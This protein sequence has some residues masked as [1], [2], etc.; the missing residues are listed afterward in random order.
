MTHRSAGAAKFVASFRNC[1]YSYTLILLGRLF[2]CAE[3]VGF[4]E[5]FSQAVRTFWVAYAYFICWMIGLYVV[6]TSFFEPLFEKSI[7]S[8]A[9]VY[10]RSRN[11]ATHVS[12]SLLWSMRYDC[13]RFSKWVAKG[14]GEG[15]GHVQL[16]TFLWNFNA[17]LCLN[18]C[19]HWNCMQMCVVSSTVSCCFREIFSRELQI[20]RSFWEKPRKWKF[21]R[22]LKIREFNIQVFIVFIGSRPFL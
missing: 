17:T 18:Y 22:C 10:R 15:W 12:L 11:E 4:D 16:W 2:S 19:C 1:F 8:F 7:F 6:K 9:T 21:R 3:N 14:V 20:R 13:Y 5:F